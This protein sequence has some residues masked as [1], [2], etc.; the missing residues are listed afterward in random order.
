[1]FHKSKY[2]LSLLTV[3]ALF[4]ATSLS[5]LALALPPV[6]AGNSLLIGS[7]PSPMGELAVVKGADDV[8][9]NGIR[10]HCNGTTRCKITEI[11]LTAYIDEDSTGGFTSGTDNA[12]NASDIVPTVSLN[13]ANGTEIFA[14]QAVTPVTGVVT[15]SGLNIRLNTSSTAVL[16]VTG[17]ISPNAY[18]NG[19][20]EDISFAVANNTDIIVENDLGVNFF[21]T[22]TANSNQATYASVLENGSLTI[23]VDPNTHKE[24]IVIAGSTDVPISTFNFIPTLESQ[25]ITDL[26]VNARQSSVYANDLADY[27][28]NINQVKL[29][30]TN[31]TGTQVTVS[32]VLVNGTANFSGLDIY[33]DKSATST[34]VDVSADLNTIAGGA[35]AGE[36]VDLA[37]AF[38]NLIS[39]GE[40]S[41][42]V[43]TIDKIDASVSNVS[44][45]DFGT[46]TWT[47]GDAETDVLIGA[48]D[49][50]LG[51]KTNINVDDDDDSSKSEEVYPVGTLFCFDEGWG[52]TCLAENIAVVTAYA[53]CTGAATPHTSCVDALEDI[54]TVMWADNAGAAM[55]A[56]EAILYALPGTGYFSSTNQMHLYESKPTLALSAASPSGAQVVSPTDTPFIFEITAD[57]N[58][59][60]TIR[61]GV[62]GDDEIDVE[63]ANITAVGNATD[64]DVALTSAAG[65]VVDGASA[66]EITAT[67]GGGFII[68]GDCFVSPTS[69]TAGTAE[70]Q[71]GSHEYV[72]FWINS[73]EP[74]L[75]YDSLGFVL[76]ADSDCANPI[77]KV[78]GDG[79]NTDDV[80]INGTALSTTG[81]PVSAV[82][83][84]GLAN[85]W[86][87]VTLRIGYSGLN[88]SNLATATNWGLSVDSGTTSLS[89][90][91]QLRIDGVVFHNE[92]LRVD[93][94]TD[95]DLNT[96]ETSGIA[97]TL[98]EAASTLASGA[99]GFLDSDGTDGSTA[100]ILF[101]PIYGTDSEIVIPQGTTKTL[102]I[103]TDTATLLDEDVGFNDPLTYSVF[104]GSSNNG[105]VTPGGLWWNESN[106]TVRWLGHLA[107][108]TLS[109]NVLNY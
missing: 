107:N 99:Y 27:D 3:A 81:S 97:A 30:Y 26:S 24:D 66:L 63:A 34:P 47:D 72:S 7:T 59:D 44:D 37:L 5:G 43:L 100:S 90:T 1:M 25:T 12:V 69:L 83:G 84:G 77:E 93:V 89:S 54:Y 87:L 105:T 17:D 108:N 10:L 20:A 38:N 78:L 23:E 8:K 92:M 96:N 68:D 11:R 73:S 28:N 45:L 70:G 15:F 74:D 56:N 50:I 104:L 75:T 55:A 109:G 32:S 46:I 52:G 60:I 61:T 42:E 86:D 2:F 64:N 103:E 40:Y 95:D 98:K 88:Y 9:F 85:H 57:A 4:I 14:P 39:V 51:S 53:S 101:V 41:G 18:Q 36:F 16:Y 102:T 79:G 71:L 13:S 49:V 65:E 31:S 48:G 80:Y 62:A 76:S 94:A 67:T 106:A 19:D 29:D 35:T 22:G 91:D 21:P 82:I 6:V 58:E 33:V